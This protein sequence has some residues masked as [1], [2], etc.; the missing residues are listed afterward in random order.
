VVVLTSPPDNETVALGVEIALTADASDDVGVT[1]VE[2]YVDSALRCTDPTP[3]YGC[4][5]TAAAPGTRQVLARAFDAA[6]NVGDSASHSLIVQAPSGTA[7][8]FYIDYAN[9][10]NANPGTS[11]TAPWKTHPYMQ[12]DAACTSGAVGWDGYSH[13][14][15]EQ[16]IFKGGVSWPAACFQMLIPAGGNPSAQDYYGVDRAWYAGDSW[17]RRRFALGFDVPAGGTV[18]QSTSSDEGYHTFDDLEIVHQGIMLG[19]YAVSQAYQFY[20]GATGTIITNNYIH[21]WATSSNVG[22]GT[23]E[24]SAGAVLGRV[25][26]DHT[27][28]SDE[29]G[30]IS[31]GGTRVDVGFGGACENCLEVKH[32]RIHH[33]M[34]G[35]FSVPSC[36]DNELDHILGEIQAY[37]ADVHSQVIEDDGGSGGHL[38]YNNL[39]HDN[40]PVGVTIY[41]CDTASIFNNVMWNNGNVRI[42]VSSAGCTGSGAGAVLNVYNNIVDCPDGACF[43]TDSKGTLPGTAKVWNNLWISDG[44]PIFLA[45][46]ITTLDASSNVTLTIAE[47]AAQGYSAENAYHST[48]SGRSAAGAGANL[49][50]RCSGELSALCRNLLHSSRPSTGPWEAGAY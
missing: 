37:D 5:Y 23:V 28:I 14:P 16:F 49:S 21:D 19:G 40:N 4:M 46:P 41:E 25:V 42:L 43:G 38:V 45:S 3:P 2:F 13:Q 36:H 50:S 15:G 44:D 11:R 30:S 27:E 7:R 17:S 47:A 22:F 12:T 24:Y 18:I 26:L 33:T 32:S 29:A 1:R 8:V 20:Y 35:C 6:E 39:I 31:V 34:A 48:A 10:S 9:G